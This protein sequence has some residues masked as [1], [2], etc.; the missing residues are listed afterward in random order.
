ML[1]ILIGALS[2]MA[3]PRK[4]KEAPAEP[5]PE[6]PAPRIVL[7]KPRLTVI[8]AVFAQWGQYA[9]WSNGTTQVA[10]WNGTAKAYTDC[11]EVIRSG[12]QDYFRSIPSLTHP[13]LTHG[14][15]PS[16]P[17]LQF[18]ETEQQRSAWLAE[19]SRENMQAIS[20]GARAS[21]H[22]QPDSGQAPSAPAAP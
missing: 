19:V 7:D 6:P 1:G 21:L 20:A 8:E 15:A 9:S 17:P 13:V 3:L 4:E 18:T 16:N 5:A 12:D 11:F 22:P 10:L 2:V 14:T